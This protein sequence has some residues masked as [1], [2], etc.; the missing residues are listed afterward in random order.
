[1]LFWMILKLIFEVR[2]AIDGGLAFF[3]LSNGN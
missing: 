1:V 2:E 3:F